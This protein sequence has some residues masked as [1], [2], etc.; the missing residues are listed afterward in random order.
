MATRELIIQSTVTALE[1]LEEVKLGKKI[2]FAEVESYDQAL[3][4]LGNDSVKVLTVIN[5]G[6]A[7]EERRLA[8]VDESGW[9]SYTESGEL[10]GEYTGKIVDTE[11]GKQDTEQVRKSGQKTRKVLDGRRY[12][13]RDRAEAV[14]AAVFAF[15]ARRGGNCTGASR[16]RGERPRRRIADRGSERVIS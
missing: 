11:N 12:V 5:D 6:L 9:H 10:N 4:R 13:F 14:F 8:R 1:T 2:Q 15:G 7:A 16:R 3:A